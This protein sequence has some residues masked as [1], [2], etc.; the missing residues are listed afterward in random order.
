[1]KTVVISFCQLNSNSRNR[2][3]ELQQVAVQGLQQVAHSSVEEP[4]AEIPI[5]TKESTL[6]KFAMF[7]G[8]SL[9]I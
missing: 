3:E 7:S 4:P 6:M 8:I 9:S 1:V 5:H 2:L